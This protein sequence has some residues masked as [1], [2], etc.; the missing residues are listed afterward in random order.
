[1]KADHERSDE[2]EALLHSHMERWEELETKARACAL[3][4]ASTGS[5]A[6]SVVSRVSASVRLEGCA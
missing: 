3:A 4:S 2:L 1:M 6:S 5:F